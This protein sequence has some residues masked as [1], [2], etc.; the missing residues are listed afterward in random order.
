MALFLTELHSR[1]TGAA[2]ASQVAADPDTF[3]RVDLGD[4]GRFAESSA[5][6]IGVATEE[7]E[8]VTGTTKGWA[9][10]DTASYDVLCSVKAWQGE[11]DDAGRLERM[12]RAWSLLE[13]V[14]LQLQPAVEAT[15]PA[16]VI[17]AMIT[18]ENYVG[19]IDAQEMPG[20]LVQFV[21]R[22]QMTRPH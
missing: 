13:M 22:V 4:P 18:R 14:R 15:R 2:I 6:G 3:I 10:S 17:S 9:G 7:T 16:G 12:A 11:D 20:A 1:C 21:V 8:S 19:V 5:I